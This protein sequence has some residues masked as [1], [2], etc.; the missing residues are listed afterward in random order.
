MTEQHPVL[1][2][3][4]PVHNNGQVGM[5]SRPVKGVVLSFI[6]LPLTASRTRRSDPRSSGLA[7]YLD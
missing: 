6:A 1:C 3:V 7:P 5:V 4:A 2:F